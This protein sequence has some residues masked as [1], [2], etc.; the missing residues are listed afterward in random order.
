MK[1]CVR[2]GARARKSGSRLVKQLTRALDDDRDRG[3]SSP[4]ER[5]RDK[6]RDGDRFTECW[7]VQQV[8]EWVRTTWASP[9]RSGTGKR[10]CLLQ[11]AAEFSR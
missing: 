7:R 2:G 11:R 6:P 1:L 10:R 5:D 9:G 3:A 4:V 8:R